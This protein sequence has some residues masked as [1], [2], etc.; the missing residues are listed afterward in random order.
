[1]V[2]TIEKREVDQ[3]FAYMEFSGLSTDDKPVTTN[4]ATGSVFVEVDTGKV[5][6]FDEVG[7]TWNEVGGDE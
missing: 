7:A 2:R 4:M 3:G 6:L 5:Y 1:M